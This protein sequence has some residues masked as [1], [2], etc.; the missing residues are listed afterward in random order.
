[1]TLYLNHLGFVPEAAKFCLLG[2]TWETNFSVRDQT[3]EQ[4]VFTSHLKRVPSDFGVYTQGEFSDITRPGVYVIEAGRER[5][6]PFHISRNVYDE[7][8]GQ[9]VSYFAL[10]RCGA[11]NISWH[12][13]CH[14]DDG[15][16]TDTHCCQD[17]EGGWH[18]A[19]DLRKWVSATLFGM[20]G[21][22]RLRDILTPSWDHSLIEDE[23]RWGN[24]YFLKMQEPDGYLMN[25]CAG[26]YYVHA[27]N[28][29][30]TD[31]VRDGKDDRTIDTKPCD[32][33]SQWLFVL[34]ESTVA[35]LVRSTDQ[36]YAEQC[37]EAARHCLGWL[38][39]EK[40][41][42]TAGELG[43]ALSG[44][45]EMYR[46][47]GETWML[48]Q[49]LDYAENLLALQVMRQEDSRSPVWGF[50]WNQDDNRFEPFRSLWQ[51]CWSLM[52]L[53]ELL[54]AC[55]D[56]EKARDW[57]LAIQLY[58]ERYLEPMTARNAFGI[59]P[60][61]LY[62]RQ[63]GG[64]RRVGRFWYRWFYE[65]NPDWYVGINANL[66]STGVGLVKAA[67]LLANPRWLALAQR[68][69]D[70]ILG[71]NPF[72]A[73]TVMGAGY[74]NPQHMFGEEFYPPTPFLP[75]AVMNGISG[76]ADDEPQLR[77]GSYQECEYWTPMVCYTMWLL[78][79]LQSM[80]TWRSVKTVNIID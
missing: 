42:Q 59:V 22:S 18:D 67:R 3:T 6:Y 57:S 37:E 48:K 47:T 33:I 17:V 68:Q 39:T 79:E 13:P 40:R 41:T 2:G 14:L 61:G 45:V 19:C 77:P 31:N 52:G 76:N 28:N 73:S 64:H 62:R 15:L 51:G 36:A 65:E 35:R 78:A 66:A 8:I 43:A 80:N 1:M 46:V 72:N 21:L 63:Q 16:R 12:G 60:Y 11:S 20:L 23:L 55:P 70:W 32:I 5:S 74:N 69:L 24:R 50:F 7:T 71:A 75:G 56:D 34:I 9:M 25:H 30:W 44:L 10:Q 54:E 26:D 49:S 29:R 4:V 27:D 38:L 58:C 53:C